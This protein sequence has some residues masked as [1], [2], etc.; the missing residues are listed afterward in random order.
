[1]PDAF[2]RP[3]TNRRACRAP[4]PP[5]L[6]LSDRSP[7][8]GVSVPAKRRKF[9][10]LRATQQEPRAMLVNEPDPPAGRRLPENSGDAAEPGKPRGGRLVRLGEAILDALRDLTHVLA[11]LRSLIAGDYSDGMS[12][13]RQEPAARAKARGERIRREREAQKLTRVALAKKI[14]ANQQT[15]E[16]IE[17]GLI[18]HSS[19][20]PRVFAAL[21]LEPDNAA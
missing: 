13:G 2:V 7:L 14:G 12:L 4:R 3:F 5:V 8:A 6:A 21:G 1:M 18:K 15:I 16:K 10:H 9:S 19:I 17:R 20:M 11:A